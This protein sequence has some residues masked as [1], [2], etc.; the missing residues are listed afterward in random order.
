MNIQ[1]QCSYSSILLSR[2]EFEEWRSLGQVLWVTF[3]KS[4]HRVDT[5]P[6]AMTAVPE[7]LYGLVSRP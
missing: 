4:E 3:A 2:F 1:R 6:W 5:A 7:S